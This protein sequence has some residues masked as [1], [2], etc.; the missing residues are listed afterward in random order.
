MALPEQLVTMTLSSWPCS[1]RAL[2]YQG[3]HFVFLETL[4]KAHNSTEAEDLGREGSGAEIVGGLCG[5]QARGGLG[6]NR[7]LG[8]GDLWRLLETGVDSSQ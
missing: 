8:E 1:G 7:R 6:F 5:D 4:L 3:F 2:S